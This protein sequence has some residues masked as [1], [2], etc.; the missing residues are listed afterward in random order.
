MT[1]CILGRQPALGLAELESLFGFNALH[2]LNNQIVLVNEPLERI[3][4]AH[5]GGT[6]K[7]AKPV[8]ILPTQQWSHI[9]DY[10]LTYLPEHLSHLPPGKLTLGL[11]VYGLPVSLTQLQRSS[12]TLKKK[13]KAT[14]RP[15]RIVPNTERTLNSAQVLHNKLDREL[16]IELLCIAGKNQTY[17]A[18]TTSIQDVESYSRRDFSRPRRDAFVGMLPPKL[19]QIM[20]NLA[21]PLPQATILDPFCG[22]GVVLMEAALQGYRL[23]GS[24]IEPKMVTYTRENLQWLEETYHLTPVVKELTVADATTHQWRKA[25]S[26]V[27][28]TYLGQPLS[29]I[30]KPEKLQTIRQ[31]CD[32]II[33]KFLTNLHHQLKPGARC[34]IAVPAWNVNNRFLHL[35]LLDD[36]KKMGYNRVSFSCTPS[37]ELLYY[38]PEQIVAREL[39]VLTRK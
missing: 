38:R 22:T 5:L 31:N 2:P 6:I 29:G 18:Q 34:T 28:E 39:L 19:A 23:E 37:E 30:P 25:D 33:R 17:I 24:D 9:L 27:C 35:P 4:H 36:L 8:T 13:L 14:G 11:S 16:G 32:T 10:C 7:I 1:I 21:K 15:I 26:V 12:L 3:K 20:L